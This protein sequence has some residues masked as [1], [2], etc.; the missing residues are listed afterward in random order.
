MMYDVETT[1]D[2]RSNG[3]LINV[4]TRQ[5]R[6]FLSLDWISARHIIMIWHARVEQ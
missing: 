6:L 3:K 4:L 2:V 5:S 1:I